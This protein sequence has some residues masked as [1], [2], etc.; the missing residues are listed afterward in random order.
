MP[1][2]TVTVGS[3]VGLHARPAAIIAEA[4][5]EL[6]SEVFLA[7][8]GEEP[9]EADSALLIM[10]LGAGKGAT[11]EVSGEDAAAV[12]AIAALVARDLDA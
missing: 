2:T 8:P 11:I 6:G 1:T 7:V 5:E 4:A 12:E 3:A 9:V 10:T